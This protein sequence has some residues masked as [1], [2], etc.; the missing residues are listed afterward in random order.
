LKICI[1]RGSVAA[2]LRCA[3]IFNNHGIT[4]FLQSAAVK[5]FFFEI[6]Q[7]VAKI[8]TIKVRRFWKNSEYVSARL[9]AMFTGR[10]THPPRLTTGCF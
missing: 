9:Q 10:G 4:K 5:E 6:G 1:S 7:Y 2:R 3:G 8:W